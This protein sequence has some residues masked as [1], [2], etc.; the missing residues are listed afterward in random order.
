MSILSHFLSFI[1]LP[2]GGNFFITTWKSLTENFSLVSLS[3]DKLSI[4]ALLVG[5][6]LTCNGPC[7]LPLLKKMVS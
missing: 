7:A 6:Q 5:I 1:F 3:A 4:E 2:P